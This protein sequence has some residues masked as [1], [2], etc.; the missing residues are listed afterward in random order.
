M[1]FRLADTIGFELLGPDLSEDVESALRTAL[2]SGAIFQGGS[3]PLSIFRATVQESIREIETHKRGR[4]FQKFLRDGPYENEGDI[5]AELRGQRV[6]DDETASAIAFIYSFMINHFKGALTELLAA[7]PCQR[8]IEQLRLSGVLPAPTRLYVGDAVM[9]LRKTG[10]GV[11]KGADMH[12]LVVNGRP[13][14]LG[15]TVAGVGEVKS[16]RKSAGAMCRQLDQHILRTRNGIRVAGVSYPAG[17]VRV[18]CGQKA[19]VVRITV[20]PSDWKLPRTFRFE[21]TERGRMLRVDATVAPTEDDQLTHV[22]DGRWHIT[23]KS[24]KEAIAQAAY[25]MTFWYMENVGEVIYSDPDAIPKDWREMTPAEAGRN[26]VKMMLYYAI[27]RCRAARDSQR[28]IALFNTYGFGYAIGMSFRDAEGK[29][30]VLFPEDLDE[31]LQSGRETKH[32][33][34]LET[35]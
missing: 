19:P 33:S 2:D 13:V 11:L 15:V 32:G 16:G 29:R 18:G 26:A 7:A 6:T 12:A 5:P 14:A 10:R 24:S 17:A 20:Q 28:A 8:L 3:D 23:L 21:D 25:E 1:V 30:S 22:G 35:T 9:V 34:R 31:I 4:L 27:L